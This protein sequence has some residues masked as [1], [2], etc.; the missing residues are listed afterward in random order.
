ME[1]FL[2]ITQ[3]SIPVFLMMGVG[4][5]LAALKQFPKESFNA[6][7][8]ID[9]KALIPCL[10]VDSI[11]GNQALKNFGTLLSAPVFGIFM[12]LLGLGAGLAT[13]RVAGLSKEEAPQWRS[14]AVTVGLFN[15]GYIPF[16]L[17]LALY[18]QE[19]VGVLF[20]FN[21]GIEICVWTIIAALLSGYSLLKEWKKIFNMPLLAI[22]FSLI[23][24]F[25]GVPLP[26]VL[27]Q[28]CYALGQCAYPLG[29]VV[30]GGVIYYL[31]REESLL[32]RLR[33]PLTATV[34][35]CGL[36]PILTLLFDSSSSFANAFVKCVSAHLLVPYRLSPLSCREEERIKYAALKLC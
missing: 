27:R 1:G 35:R 20:V 17:A 23:L 21:V 12:L 32:D 9:V 30:C 34:L 14:Y 28:T 26:G 24:N 15:Y 4:Y 13:R 25:A 11:L 31:C 29:L 36:L 33:A 2:I 18:D 16:P 22:I 8:N 7:L 3:A 6:I 10:I 5:L 19:T